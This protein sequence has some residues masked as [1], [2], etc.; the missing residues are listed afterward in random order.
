MAFYKETIF[1]K[2]EETTISRLASYAEYEVRVRAHNA[3]GDG[4][5]SAAQV[6]R[7]DEDGMRKSLLNSS[8]L[9]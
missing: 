5:L 2:G 9:L 4:P 8:E 7:T 3:A 1:S 6:C